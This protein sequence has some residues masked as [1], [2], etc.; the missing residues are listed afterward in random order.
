VYPTGLEDLVTILREH[1]P[2]ERIHAAGSHWSLSRA[3][4]S[5]GVFVE[6]HDPNDA[7]P[8]MGRTL[9]DVVPGCLTEAFLQGLAAE[10]PEP[11]D[12]EHVGE[13]M[14]R[15]LFHFET[16]KRVYQAYAEMD[17]GDGDDPRSLAAVLRDRFNNWCYVGEWAFRTL[18]GAGGQ[19]VFGA[20]RPAPTAATSAAHRSRTR[21]RRCTS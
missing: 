7:H 15:Y 11:F 12:I 17:L 2:T 5:D 1:A 3:A 13:D 6:T 4:V 21:C 19:T 8:A 10:H 9:Y 20:S 16:G 18:G 14:G